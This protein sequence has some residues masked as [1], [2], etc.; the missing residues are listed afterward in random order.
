VADLHEPREALT[1]QALDMKRAIDSMRE[2]LEA[3][4]WYRQRMLAT[5]DPAL[6]ALLDHHQREEIEHFVMLLEWCRRNDADFAAQMKTYLFKSG[7]LLTIEDGDTKS[8]NEPQV[9]ERRTT[10]GSMRSST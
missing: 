8:T 1:E 6:R 9:R 5:K 10:I 3:V 7:D 2:E 4:D